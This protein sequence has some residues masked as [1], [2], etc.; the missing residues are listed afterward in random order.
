MF[1]ART[2]APPDAPTLNGRLT[3]YNSGTAGWPRPG[4]T[5]AAGAADSVE[6]FR[7]GSPVSFRKS[8]VGRSFPIPATQG[9]H[10]LIMDKVW[11]RRFAVVVA[12]A[13]FLLVLAGALTGAQSGMVHRSIGVLVGLMAVALAIGTGRTAASKPVRPIAWAAAGCVALQGILGALSL[14]NASSPV[15]RMGHSILADVVFALAV[16]V[17]LMLQP[18]S[19]GAGP[20]DDPRRHSLLTTSLAA[21]V[22][23]VVQLGLGA[24]LRQ[25][26]IG[27]GLHA[28]VAFA[29]LATLLWPGFRILTRHYKHEPLKLTA[30]VAIVCSYLQVFLGLAIYA[31]RFM[32]GAIGGGT[33]PSEFY[34]R[35]HVIGGAAML[36]AAAA[37]PV[38]I[39]RYLRQP[40]VRFDQEGASTA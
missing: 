28:M 5:R 31:G 15:F 32:S 37:I 20:V 26:L 9:E 25:G 17:A 3:V 19:D 38:Q 23:I 36:G 16:V 30:M 14:A 21:S 34:E 33:A 10:L 24:A 7:A 18:A 11:L 40:A 1:R 6:E 12:A 27:M 4:W 2:V 22:V 29:A 8:N 39:Q 13:A 35:A